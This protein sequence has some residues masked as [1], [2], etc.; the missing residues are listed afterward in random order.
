MAGV[1]R[2]WSLQLFVALSAA[3]VTVLASSP[4]DA[5]A[6][7]YPSLQLPTASTRDYT[8]GIVGGRGS[9]IVVQ[10]RERFTAGS[11]FGVDA[12]L[13]NPQ[14]RNSLLLFVA[15]SAGQEVLRASGDQPLDILAT[16]GVGLAL[17]GRTSLLRVPIGA[18][19][20]HTFD[21]G[22]TSAG[23]SVTPYVHPRLSLDVC[24]NCAGPNGRQANVSVNFD[25]G[26]SLQVNR[27][28]AVRAAGVFSGGN[29]LGTGDAFTVGF[30]WTPSAL[31][32]SVVPR[33]SAKS[34]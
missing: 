6:F 30:S 11:Q 22:E 26:A 29:L 20:G 16:A 17:G 9:T 21:L 27:Q 15:G 12:G 33:D 19:I 18:S 24:N 31:S 28:F 5:Q 34:P 2:G 4:A 13:A 1:S 7:N 8:A 3:V 10:W 32:T 25:L 23:M 14:T